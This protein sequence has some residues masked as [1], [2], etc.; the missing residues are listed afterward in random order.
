[1]AWNEAAL[2]RWLSRRL[3]PRGLSVG[4]GNDAAVLRSTPG[5]A[6]VCCDQ[7]IAGVH[8]EPALGGARVGRKAAGRALSDLAASAARPRALLVSGSFS[9]AVEERWIRAALRGVQD[10]ARRFGAEL[11]GGD[12]ACAPS[13][14]PASLSVTALGWLAPGDRAVARDRAR[15]GHV[16]VLTG[17]VGGSS[18]G[19]HLSFEPRIAAGRWLA[20]HGAAA[21]MDVS[22][23]LALDLSRL[24]RASGVRMR[25]ERVPIHPAAR[26][27]AR[28]TGRTPLEHALCD[29]E[30]YELLAT[31]PARSWSRVAGRAAGHTLA[32]GVELTVVGRVEAGTGLLVPTGTGGALERWDASGGW[33]H[34]R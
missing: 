14:S 17:A 24:G 23:G 27:L 4:F 31:L 21:V 26:R 22:D 13:G 33:V 5:R 25:L 34:G 8:F 29:G 18:L 1:M 9:P 3:K 19:R 28:T 16:I 2:H 30:D 7:S 15:P 11:V 12:L 20:R 10:T 6:V 32:G